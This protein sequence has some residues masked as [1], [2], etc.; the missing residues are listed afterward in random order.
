MHASILIDS[1]GNKFILVVLNHGDKG[2]L[3]IDLDG[4]RPLT[5]RDKVNNIMVQPLKN[6]LLHN[7]L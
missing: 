4:T 6:I 7:L 2:F 3:R 1:Y 5:I